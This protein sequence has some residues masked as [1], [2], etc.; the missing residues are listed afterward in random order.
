MQPKTILQGSKRAFHSWLFRRRSNDRSQGDTRGSHARR[1]LVLLAFLIVPLSAYAQVT[2]TGAIQ[3]ATNAG[4]A[5]SENQSWNTLGGDACWDLWLAQNPD[6]SSPVNGPSD[7]Q[8]SIDI[9]LSAGNSYKFYTFGAPDLGISFNGLNLFFD[10][11]NSTPGISVFGST[12]SRLFS[13]DSSSSTR[14]LAGALVTGSGTANY[15]AGGVVAVLTGYTWNAPATPPGDVCQAFTF[16]PGGGVSF[17]GSFTL[18]VFP[19]AALSL[20][21]TSGSPGTKVTLTGSGFAPTEA[22]EIYA[23]HIGVPPVLAS[24]TTDASGSFA[25][26]A[27]EPEHPYGPMDVYAVGVSSHKLGAATLSVTSA[28]VMNPATGAPGSTTAAYGLGFGAGETVDIYWNNPR[29][30]L[31]TATANGEGS[32]ALTISIPADASPGINLVI[33]V[34]QTT[35]AIGIGGIAVE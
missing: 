16:D 31:G 34:G 20:N 4:G 11:D 29:Q 24:T 5:F 1:S 30:L 18:Q 27:R 14:T 21:Q 2:L 12:N 8:A 28:L 9:P 22:V 3:F 35:K 15:A 17:S 6:A 26:S 33:G 32:G 23:G 10:G 19:S 7:E 13:P 25:D